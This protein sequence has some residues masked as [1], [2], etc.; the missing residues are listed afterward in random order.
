MTKI[1]KKCQVYVTIWN[2][3]RST[4]KIG[5]R[6]MKVSTADI[7]KVVER[8]Q[9][10]IIQSHKLEGQD[11]IVYTFPTFER[12]VRSSELLT[13]RRTIREKWDNL[14]AIGVLKDERNSRDTSRLFA[15]LS[16]P[17][18][19]IELGHEIPLP[20]SASAPAS[21]S[22]RVSVSESVSVSERVSAS[23]N[24]TEPRGDSE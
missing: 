3:D 15:T 2:S 14:V 21:D 6:D 11:T 17:D 8:T 24:E 12:A 20:S 19:E 7:L 10:K 18:L 23:K 4:N 13:S 5:C 1:L 16:I 9:A 22:E